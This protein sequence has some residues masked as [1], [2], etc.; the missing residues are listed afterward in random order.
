V[1]NRGG[2]NGG[3]KQKHPAPPVRTIV[4]EECDIF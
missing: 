2:T 3:Q 4:L 1:L